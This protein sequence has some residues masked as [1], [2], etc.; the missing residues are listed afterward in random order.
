M[1]DGNTCSSCQKLLNLKKPTKLDN[2]KGLY[3]VPNAVKQNALSRFDCKYLL[4]KNEVALLA[5]LSYNIK[6]IK[7]HKSFQQF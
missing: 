2:S 5:N 1:L 7:Q 6:V 4:R 3:Y